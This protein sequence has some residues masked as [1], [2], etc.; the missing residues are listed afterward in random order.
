MKAVIPAAGLGTRFLPATK[1]QPKEMLPVF[2]KP[3]IQYV[4]EEAV[5]SGIDDI[6]I[7]TGK[8]KRS[9]EDHFDRSFELEYN[10]KE[11]KKED[12][13]NE[14]LAI[15]DLADIYYVRQKKQK[16]LGDAIY[17]AKK[18]I[19]DEPF[20]VMLGDTITK[21]EIPCTKQL[22]NIY[23]KYDASAIAVEPVPCEK[24]ERYGIIKG[25]EIEESVYKIDK[26][27]EKPPVNEAPSNLAIM[28]RYVLS[29]EVF[30]LLKSTN[31]GHGG[32]IQ[33][34]DALA[35]LSSI[36]G[37]A[38]NGKSHDI[39]NRIDWLK[40]S[41][42]FALCDENAKDGLIEFMKETIIKYS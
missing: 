36:Y 12:Y 17:C 39:G 10:L 25:N 19:G 29:N 40:T 6:L 9:I 28:G 38:F 4:I 32:E 30:D 21:D 11:N 34:T 16:G 42:E 27:I 22:I 33:L 23:N 20:A 7:V 37:Y 1:A 8:G 41:L 14:V 31:P 2:D 13:L 24:V 26:L 35:K 18:H 5:A 15:S 3:T